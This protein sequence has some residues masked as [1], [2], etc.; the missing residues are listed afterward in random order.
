MDLG[1]DEQTLL[2]AGIGGFVGFLVVSRL[3]LLVDRLTFL[4]SDWL[5]IA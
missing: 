2:V 5:G 1:A 3:A 4:L